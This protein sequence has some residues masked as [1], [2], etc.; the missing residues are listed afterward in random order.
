MRGVVELPAIAIFTIVAGS[1]IIA[2]FV[3]VS[4]QQSDIGK[5]NIERAS[6][7]RFDALLKSA[8]TARET[9]NNITVIDETL[10][11]VCDDVSM[12]IEYESHTQKDFH[13]MVM[14]APHKLEGGHLR[15]YSKGVDSPYRVTNILYVATDTYT[16][17]STVPLYEFPSNIEHAP[18]ASAKRIVRDTGNPTRNTIVVTESP[19]EQLGTVHYFSPTDP[20][21]AGIVYPNRELYYGAILAEDAQTYTCGLNAY[22]RQLRFVNKIEWLRAQQLYIDTDDEQC[23]LSYQFGPFETIEAI[24]SDTSGFTLQDA[25]DLVQ[26]QREIAF[27]N[28]KLLRGDGCAILY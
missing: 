3:M 28:D 9:Q 4:Q 18:A 12:R 22:L 19:G 25:R 6:L 11:Y 27:L 26:A 5:T 8:A 16:V 14:F 13:N 23:K 21:G 17:N 15:V 24:T 10:L 1:L 20:A 2:F 7:E